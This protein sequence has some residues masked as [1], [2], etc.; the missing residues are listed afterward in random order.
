[1]PGSQDFAADP[2]NE[3]VLIYLN[4]D[5]VRRADAKVSI[6]DAGFVLGDGVWEG[7]RLHKGALVFLDAHLDRLYWGA[8][9]IALDL[10]IDRAGLCHA[11][12]QTLDAN[13]MHD[14]VHIRVMATRG[15][16]KL[17]LIHI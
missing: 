12:K 6:F 17:S 2:R 9:E 5:L 8:K 10:G 16:K 7:V 15:V 13:K 1:M 11:I 14:G 4:G 3:N